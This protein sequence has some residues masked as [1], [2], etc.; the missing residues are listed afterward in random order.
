MKKT[1]LFLTLLLSAST[2][3]CNKPVEAPQAIEEEKTAEEEA[4]F[5]ELLT[6]LLKVAEQ[7]EKEAKN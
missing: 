2:A 7:V 6:E 3:L 5:A 1:T 4:P